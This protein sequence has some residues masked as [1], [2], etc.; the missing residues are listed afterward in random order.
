MKLVEKIQKAAEE[1]DDPESAARDLKDLMT[2]EESTRAWGK[3][4]T[5]LKNQSEEE[6]EAHKNKSKEEKGQAVALFLMKKPKFQGWTQSVNA[7][8][9]PGQGEVWTSEAKLVKGRV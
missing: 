2:K 7:Q 6:Q 4:N 1:N 8:T 5:W 3:H 9:S